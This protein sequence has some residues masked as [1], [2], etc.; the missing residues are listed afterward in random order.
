V[1]SVRLSLLLLALV[2]CSN[3]AA[4]TGQLTDPT[5]TI[6]GPLTFSVSDFPAALGVLWIAPTAGGARGA[7][8]AT[9]IRYGSL[10][11]TEVIGRAEIAGTRVALHVDYSLRRGVVCGKDIRALRYDA[12]IAG[13]APG[14][15]DVH[16]L[17]SEDGGAESEVRVQQVDVT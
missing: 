2:G 12:V 9:S 7:I 4:I 1:R 13:L 16:L 14:R 3:G 8:T 15:Y 10:C 17:H 11:T 6:D 5:V